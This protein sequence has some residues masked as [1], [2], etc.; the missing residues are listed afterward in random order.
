MARRIDIHKIRQPAGY[1]RNKHLYKTC[2]SFKEW[3]SKL[4]EGYIGRQQ[5]NLSR[6]YVYREKGAIYGNSGSSEYITDNTDLEYTKKVFKN[7]SE[8]D[9]FKGYIYVNTYKG[10]PW[11]N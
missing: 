7:I 8:I 3:I 10:I 9:D 1:T 11:L 6:W 5:G 4:K 2:Y